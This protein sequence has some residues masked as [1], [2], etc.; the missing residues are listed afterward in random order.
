VELVPNPL[1]VPVGIVIGVLIAL[2]FGPVNLLVLQRAAERGFLGGLAAALGVVL[3]DGLIAFLAA[4]GVNALSGAI[5]EYR[6]AVQ[7]VGGLALTLAGLRCILVPPDP[8]SRADAGETSLRDHIWSI[9][10]TFLL[11]LTSP[12]AVLGLIAI[13]G[14]ASSYVEVASHVDAITLVASVMGGALAYW[15]LV[16]RAIGR[17]RHLLDVEHL[18]KIS[19]AAGLVLVV[20]GSLLMAQIALKQLPLEL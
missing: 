14:G 2:P 8:V 11:T 6:T 4:M 12:A 17:L 3:G 15:I 5:F 20:S 19:I 18:R 16:T 9:P 7:V 10:E 1:V 13:F